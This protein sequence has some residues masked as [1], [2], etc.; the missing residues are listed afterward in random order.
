MPS[1]TTGRVDVTKITQASIRLHRSRGFAQT[2]NVCKKYFYFCRVALTVATASPLAR[3]D[4]KQDVESRSAY[5]LYRSF[6]SDQAHTNSSAVCSDAPRTDTYS[7]RGHVLD[8][9]RKRIVRSNPCGRDRNHGCGKTNFGAG[10]GARNYGMN[11]WKSR[12]RVGNFRRGRTRAIGLPA[13]AASRND[14]L[15]TLP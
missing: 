4:G 13:T 3:V 7:T 11:I 6:T 2:E 9:R 15:Q 14:R 10:I 8:A 1:R 12:R 5:R